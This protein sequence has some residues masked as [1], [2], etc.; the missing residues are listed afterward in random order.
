M[1]KLTIRNVD[2][3]LA[4][5]LRLR[6]AMHHRS[7]SDEVQAI[8]AEAVADAPGASASP[9]ESLW[10]AIRRVVEPLGGIE[11]DLPPREAVREPPDFS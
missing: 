10:H 4:R 1:T 6:A 2:R 9:A 7:L 5:K 3:D 8:L 11:L